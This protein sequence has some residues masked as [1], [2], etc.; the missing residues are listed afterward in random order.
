MNEDFQFKDPHPVNPFIGDKLG[1]LEEQKDMSASQ[2][3]DS[4]RFDNVDSLRQI[5]RS[6]P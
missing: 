2:I 5:E 3:E 6:R 4:E 1:D